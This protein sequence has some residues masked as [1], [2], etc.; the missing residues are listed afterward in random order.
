MPPAA[1]M[2]SQSVPARRDKAPAS[3]NRLSALTEI[4]FE[5]RETARRL[6]HCDDML[7]GLRRAAHHLGAQHVALR[8]GPVAA[9]PPQMPEHVKT[10][11]GVLRTPVVD[12]P[13]AQLLQSAGDLVGV[14]R[15][16]R[17]ELD[18]GQ[19]EDSA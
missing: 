16:A 18:L 19:F 5:Q 12:R 9:L 8:V 4:S 17:A 11:A 7:G 2:A 15:P 3:S 10:E 13:L 6:C 14:L 1:A